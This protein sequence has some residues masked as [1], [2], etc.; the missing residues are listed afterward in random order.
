MGA[1]TPRPAWLGSTL[2]ARLSPDPSPQ[3]PW[4]ESPLT[5]ES[6]QLSAA[7][8]GPERPPGPKG[9]T[10]HGEHPSAK[11]LEVDSPEVVGIQVFDKFFHLWEE[12]GTGVRS[13]ETPLGGVH[14]AGGRLG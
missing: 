5:P 13:P 2:R 7:G 11:V 8:R 12:G 14:G 9:L 3:P 6:G 4:E 1:G 10:F